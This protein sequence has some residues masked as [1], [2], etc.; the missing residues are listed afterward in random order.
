MHVNQLWLGLACAFALGCAQAAP[1]AA[2]TPVNS[3]F[4]HTASQ[5]SEVAGALVLVVAL[6]LG[7]A[8]G[9]RKFL[10]LT[11]HASGPMKVLSALPMGPKEKLLLVQVGPTQ[12]VLSV[13]PGRIQTVHVLDEPLS[14]AVVNEAGGSAFA[15]HLQGASSSPL[16]ATGLA[17]WLPRGPGRR[18]EPSS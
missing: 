17:R 12:L 10:R 5:V 16:R 4:E 6:I 8:W 14:E 13:V 1:D 11:P 7:L 2:G 15:A 9:T 18:G 3:A